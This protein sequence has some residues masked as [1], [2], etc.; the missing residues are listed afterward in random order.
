MNSRSIPAVVTLPAEIDA[1]SRG[2]AYGRLQAACVSGASVVIADF[3]GTRFCDAGSMRRLLAA[4]EMA[5]ASATQL[6]FAIPPGSPIRRLAGLLDTDHRIPV[7]PSPGEAAA[8]TTWPRSPRPP[9]P[10]RGTGQSAPGGDNPRTQRPND[11]CP[12]RHAV[13]CRADVPRV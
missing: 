2:Y 1:Y 9:H 13:S 5:A 12:E 7:Y 4:F 8:V 3:A 10:A 11:G 6:R